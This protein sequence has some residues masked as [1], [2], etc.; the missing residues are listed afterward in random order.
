M[1]DINDVFNYVMNTPDNTN[2][3]VLRSM[4]NSIEGG[5]GGG[6]FMIGATIA[7]ESLTLN[8]TFSEIF[9]AAKAGSFCIIASNAE[10]TVGYMYIS[11]MNL[12]DNMAGL[13][14]AIYENGSN[15]TVS[16]E[17]I[18]LHANTPNDYPFAVLSR[19]SPNA[20]H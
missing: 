5:G 1:P 13:I 4:L 16:F 6:V 19:S 15:E 17:A 11:A 8:K 7:G 12:A 10:D 20:A 3:N 18:I 9:E 2:P 14:K